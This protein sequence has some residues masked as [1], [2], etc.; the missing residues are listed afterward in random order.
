[1]DNRSGIVAIVAGTRMLQRPA[2]QLL[3]ASIGT[4]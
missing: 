2:T 1:M 3:E 4:V